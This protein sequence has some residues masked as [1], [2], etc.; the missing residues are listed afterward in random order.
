MIA[1][2]QD[3]PFALYRHRRRFLKSPTPAPQEWPEVAADTLTFFRYVHER[4]PGP[5]KSYSYWTELETAWPDYAGM[6][7]G[8]GANDCRYRIEWHCPLSVALENIEVCGRRLSRAGAFIE[9]H[10]QIEVPQSAVKWHD[11]NDWGR[12]ES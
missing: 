12:Y 11:M 4:F 7:L 5:V 6:A 1:H 2:L 3:T 9:Y 10:V 8:I